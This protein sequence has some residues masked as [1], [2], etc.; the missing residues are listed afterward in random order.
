MIPKISRG[1]RM[2]GLMNYLAG[3]GEENQH[4]AVHLVASSEL[5]FSHPIGVELT[6][7]DAA[8]LARELDVPRR[9]FGTEVAKGHVFHCSLSLGTDDGIQTDARWA[10]I[11]AEFVDQMGFTG[12]SGKAPSRWAA[13]RHGLSGNGNDHVHIVASVIREDGTKWSDFNDRVK[14]QRIAR[15]LEEKYGFRRLGSGAAERGYQRAEP[16]VAARKG[17]VELERETLQRSVRAAASASASEAE[18][19]RRLRGTGVLVRPRFAAGRTDVIEGYSVAVRPASRTDRPVWFGGG[20]LARDL[21]LPKLRADWPATPESTLAA[22]AE[23]AAAAKNR[24]VVAPERERLTRG[25]EQWAKVAAELSMLNERLRSTPLDD[26][27]MWAQAARDTAGVLS[28]WSVRTEATPGPLADAARALRRSAQPSEPV[29]L[30]AHPPMPS[31]KGAGIMLMQAAVGP[32]TAVGQASLL[33]QLMTTM[34]AVAD[35]HREAGR[36]HE[37]NRLVLANTSALQRVHDRLEASRPAAT[38][39]DTGAKHASQATWVPERSATAPAPKPMTEDE[40]ELAELQRLRK[41]AFGAAAGG[42]PAS[43]PPTQA[44]PPTAS[45]SRGR[46]NKQG[47]SR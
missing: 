16:R 8:K 44:N 23:W 41:T 12:S 4:E 7:E 33:R 27:T 47:R 46:D 6:L 30:A 20:R 14:A 2:A 1:D 34:S 39:S 35:M 10:E 45:P 3:P 19:V 11:V 31:P 17:S 36:L 26:R 28:A 42:K 18:F 22:E 29:P 25:P 38:S 9:V 13:V 15:E 40:R 24:R 21:T 43:K 37:A 32:S 5:V